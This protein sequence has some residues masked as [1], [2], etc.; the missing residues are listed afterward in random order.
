[1]IRMTTDLEPTYQRVRS[2]IDDPD[3]RDFNLLA[4]EVFEHQFERIEPYRRYCQSVGLTPTKVSAFHAIPK[5][6]T[7][8]FKHAK[9]CIGEP[10]RV[11]VTSGTTAKGERGCHFVACLDLYRASALA[12]LRRMIFPDPIKTRILALHPTF[13]RMPDSS[14]SQMISWA[15]EEFAHRHSVCAADGSGIDSSAAIEF[16]CAAEREATPVSILATTAAF[17]S[18]IQRLRA[19]S[20]RFRLAAGSRLMDTGGPKGQA[21][22]LT[23]QQVVEAAGWF[24]GIE[25]DL[26]INE[27]GMTE[28]CSQLYDATRFNSEH[29]FPPA[30][31]IKIAPP[32]MSAWAVDPAT[33]QPVEDG[34][35]GLL[36]YFDLANA[37][38]VSAILTGD[39]GW[40]AN[41][42]VML[43]GRAPSAEARGCAL[44]MDQFARAQT[45]SAPRASIPGPL[46]FEFADLPVAAAD[47]ATSEVLDLAKVAANLRAA[48]LV[49]LDRERIVRA[50]IEA[51]SR[52]KRRDH[53]RRR[54]AIEMIGR[55]MGISRQV[56]D[57]SIDA[58]L[59]PF[60][61]EAIRAA[62]SRLKLTGE[63]IGFI[64]AGNVVGAGIHEVLLALICGAAVMAKSSSAEPYFLRALAETIARVDPEVANRIAVLSFTRERSDLSARLRALCEKMVVYGDDSTLEALHG[65]GLVGFG[66]KASGALVAAEAL[67]A[68]ERRAAVG[69]LARDVVLF[70][71]RGCLSPSH[72]FVVGRREVSQRFS[73]ALGAE[74]EKTA[75]GDF[76]PAR[77]NLNLA[78]QIQAVREAAR[79]RKIAGASLDLLEGGGLQWT[80][81]SEPDAR[82]I[83]SP[84]YRTVFVSAVEDVDDFKR[85]LLGFEGRIEGFSVA[86]PK[87]ELGGFVSY[88]RSIGVGWICP[89]GSA[90]SPPLMW[91]HGNGA[92]LGPLLLPETA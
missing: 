3:S 73:A 89:P 27:Y 6:P 12:H 78:A 1:M 52:L 20:R 4:L 30:A 7:I 31:R 92:F 65:S 80:I 23:P 18:L 44:A 72:V 54:D 32:W 45:A 69:A 81:V 57:A 48:L 35:I 63:L 21:F 85:R 43:L 55:K 91:P 51:V 79:W 74:L 76:P 47:R 14:L 46:R 26:A 40:A 70:E 88:L 58:L 42:R 39:L 19:D 67:R 11:F 15:I 62:A 66:S 2:F 41:Q 10:E 61:E 56:L 17:A 64:M 28:L 86:D 8:A 34:E 37:S 60:H 59:A 68:D 90:Q 87:S 84:G 33:L 83:V 75:R 38:S 9:F 50:V 36:A 77:L 16:L 24:F 71:Q 25:P 82:F 49:D 13:D 29:D 22:A 5:V 53:R